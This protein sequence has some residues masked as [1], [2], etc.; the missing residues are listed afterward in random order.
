MLVLNTQ[1]KNKAKIKQCTSN[2]AKIWVLFAG[3]VSKVVSKVMAEKKR[4]K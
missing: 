2:G 1:Q 4:K 3:E